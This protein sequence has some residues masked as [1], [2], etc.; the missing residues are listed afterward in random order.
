MRLLSGLFARLL[1][2]RLLLT[3]LLLP[4]LVFACLLLACLLLLF[5]A[6]LLALLA[7]LLLACLLLSILLLLLA[8]L[9][10]ALLLL[11]RLLRGSLLIALRVTLLIALL[12][13][14]R[15]LTLL[16]I[17]LLR[18]TL[19]IPLRLIPLR[20]VASLRRPRASRLI[21]ATWVVVAAIGVGALVVATRAWPLR[22]TPI[23][24]MVHERLRRAALVVV[25]EL[26]AVAAGIAYVAALHVGGRRMA[27]IARGQF[28]R[29]RRASNAI[30]AAVIADTSVIDVVDD[31]GVVVHVG[32]AGDVHV[33]H[34]AVVVEA[35]ALP[36]AAHIPQPHIAEAVVDAAIKADVG[37]PIA[38]VPHIQAIGEAP[39]AGRPERAGVG[40]EH[41]GAGHPEKAVLIAAPVAGHPHIA[42][43]RRGR[44]HVGGQG[45]RRLGAA[46]H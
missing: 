33:G 10:I 27:V 13:A 45:G 12:R 38:R 26:R 34:R 16:L 22:R 24:A 11:A 37:A 36:V 15:L 46:V 1:L 30:G 42:I 43:G 3:R 20:Q 28:A 17:T 4:G 7:L 31:H 8:S 23:V 41:P 40:G 5:A 2:T 29:V 6:L 14:T 9:L 39:V 35:V 21:A 25:V 18:T 44:L 19:L 32:D